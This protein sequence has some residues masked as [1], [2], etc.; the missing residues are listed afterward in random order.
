[1]STMSSLG[2]ALGTAILPCVFGSPAFA[3][4]PTTY[5][6][7][8]GAD[9]GACA[10]PAAA[11]RTFAYAIGKTSAGG[12]VKAINAGS[13]GPFAVDKAITITGVP[14][15][16]VL[17]GANADAVTIAAGANDAVALVGLTIDGFKGAAPNGVKLTSGGS[18]TI[19]N[20]IVRDFFGSGI[21][22]VPTAVTK[23]LIE[24]TMLTDLGWS[25][26]SAMAAPANGQ[27]AANGRIDRV[28]VSNAKWAGVEVGWSN[29][30]SITESSAA[31]SEIGFAASGNGKLVLAHS[32]ATENKTGVA[33]IGASATIESAGDNT[34]RDNVTNVQGAMSMVGTQ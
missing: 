6:S 16:G 5:V 33:R 34:I 12:E 3:L 31:N 7:I 28:S 27:S 4:T 14:G 32:F 9:A 26:V 22:L 1:M 20:C 2:V 25:G 19:K 21:A 13:F 17:Q 8:T 29:H 24:D 10:T 23:F 30:V 15:A 11:C 18:L